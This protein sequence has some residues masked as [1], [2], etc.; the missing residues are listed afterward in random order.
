[1]SD[2]GQR[3]YR[4]VPTIAWV[5]D[6]GQTLLVEEEAGR[7]WS[8]RGVEAA[9]WDWLSLGYSFDEIVGLLKVLVGASDEEAR[10]RLVAMLEGWKQAGIVRLAGS[11]G[12]G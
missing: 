10:E 1:M 9:V 5:K 7:T 6:A 12:R 8:L 3:T 11:N 4:C 2:D